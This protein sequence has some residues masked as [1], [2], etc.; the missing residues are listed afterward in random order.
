MSLDISGFPSRVLIVSLDFS[1]VVLLYVLSSFL[2]PRSASH[3]AL[4]LV[5]LGI[6]RVSE[7]DS[8]CGTPGVCLLKGIHKRLA[9]IG[10]DSVEDK[11]LN[12]KTMEL[13]ELH[14]FP[15][16]SAVQQHLPTRVSS[17]VLGTSYWSFVEKQRKGKRIR[18]DLTNW[19]VHL[20]EKGYTSK[21]LI[22]LSIQCV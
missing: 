2:D 17:M 14:A 9:S 21:I 4:K 3:R 1:L 12:S 11:S 10:V 7:S 18:G 6:G 16:P 5:H 13:G 22:H 15:P 19:E 8:S 20:K